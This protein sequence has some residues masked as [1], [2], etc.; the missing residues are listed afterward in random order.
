MG[1]FILLIII[2]AFTAGAVRQ[3]IALALTGAVFLAVW[4]YCLV[5]TLFLALLHRRRAR[6][7]FIRV[8]PREVTA[9]EMAE[10][11]YGADTGGIF[12][13]PGILVRY[14]LLLAAKDGRRIQYDFNPADSPPKTGAHLFTAEKRG[15]YFSRFDEYAV[16]DIWGFFRFAYR[17]PVEN[18]ARLLVSPHPADEPPPVN[19]HAGESLLK[20]EFSF[21]R[22]DNLIDHRPYVPGDDPR[23]INWKLYGHGSGLFVREGEFEP[24]P[25]S[26][27][28]ILV[29]TEYDPL[30]YN[31]AS[32]LHG[33]DVLCENALSAVLACA[34]SGME[35]FTGYAGG[36]ICGGNAVELAASL[37]WPAVAPLLTSGKL[38]VAPPHCGVLILALARSTAETSAIDRFL[39]DTA[40][41]PVDILFFCGSTNA[42]TGADKKSAAHNERLTAAG[43]CA[44]LYNQRSG[45]R[46]GVCGI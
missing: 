30:L 36:V 24:P 31:R 16:F 1:I 44:G 14:R 32:A 37:A 39:S 9:G 22:T 12:Q 38:P 20:P 13:L 43:V 26:N 28:V 35:A 33:V 40:N 46:A 29:D 21:Q 2:F 19:A 6:G 18:T 23:R 34:E 15:A 25:Q 27:I 42:D 3:E 11:V 4:V 41:R 10:A 7:A 45:V 5:M 17:L 8:S